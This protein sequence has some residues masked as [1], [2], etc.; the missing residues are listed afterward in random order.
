M[1]R[2]I[3]LAP[4]LPWPVLAGLGLVVLS[5]LVLAGLR[6]LPGAPWRALAAAV[7]LAALANPVLREETRQALP[8]IVL[9]V[10][11][12]TA[13]QGMGDRRDQTERALAHLESDI[14]RLPNTELRVARL[15]DAPPGS[16]GGTEAMAALAGAAAGVPRDQIAGAVLITDGRIHDMDRAP[17]LPAPVHGLLT[18][19]PGDWDLR[20]VVE[21][22]PAFAIIGE[23]VPLR[24]RIEAAGDVP[25][26][27]RQAVALDIAIGGEPARRA[28]VPV[29]ETVELSL[30]LPAG[31]ANLLQFAVP[32][33]PGELT[34][35]NNTAIVTVN[36]IRDRLSVLLVSGEPHAGERTWRNLLKAD[37]AVDLVHF[38][39]LRPPEKQD[40]VPVSELSLIAF[41]T[42]ELFLEKIEDFDL[43][44]FD[45]YRL[46]GLLP[47]VYLESV[48]DYVRGGGAVLIAA[49][50]EY[51]G[52]GSIARSPLGQVLP[53][54]PTARVI[55]AGFHPALTETGRRHPVTAGLDAEWA[56]ARPDSAAG[57]DAP[58]WGRWFR[59][60][61]VTADS[62]DAVMTGAGDRPLLILDRV[63]QG[64]VA[65]LA[66]DH[67]WLWHRGF[68]GGGP[69]KELLRRLAHW[70]MKE[71]ELEEEAL[72]AAADGNRMTI[73]RRSL[74]ETPRAVIVTAPDGTETEVTLTETAPG[75]F[76]ATHDGA[77]PGLYR[78][79]DATGT[80]P[81]TAAVA[82]GAASPR[83]F[84]APLATA[85]PLAPLAAATGGAIRP[86]ADGLPG[87]RTIRPGR[88]AHGRGWIGITPRD[89]FVTTDLRI[90]PLLPAWAWL[91]AGAGLMLLAWRREGR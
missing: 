11:D 27:A 7:V 81:L 91:L 20:V 52:A 28:L 41:P 60:V 46:R 59:H 33:Q 82:L 30:T 21:N 74:S 29:G 76:A 66:S 24:L 40:G 48:R 70:T 72:R 51:A 18:G 36:G 47:A 61:E 64:R 84:D 3:E 56:G 73:D 80:P 49:G 34:D 39:I 62:G 50:P 15:G 75:R 4:L 12:E 86:V 58:P 44:I 42:R 53:G 43:I 37:S 90:A 55:E 10:V 26:A 85:D 17:A 65:L 6:G 78:L 54:R 57:S 38:T 69:Q 16:D 14:A 1:T 8:D 87:L 67:A 9:A 77:E 79:R 5:L 68:E 2:M 25:A 71:P 31:G 32:A 45:R 19:D 13:S 89:A 88:P 83:E 22:A 35:R 23:P 63:G